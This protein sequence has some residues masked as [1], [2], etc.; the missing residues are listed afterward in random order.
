MPRSRSSKSEVMRAD[1]RCEALLLARRGEDDQAEALARTAVEV[2][3]TRTDNIWWQAYT[4]E[5]LA[6]VLERAG[7]IDEARSELE[8]VLA[9][10]ERKG[11][12]PCADRTREQLASL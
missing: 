11:C 7:R 3:E 2:A 4:H 12:L 5:D 6:T 8:R 10:W 1:S 9:I